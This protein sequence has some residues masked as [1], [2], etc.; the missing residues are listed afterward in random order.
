MNRLIFREINNRSI[1]YLYYP[2]GEEV[3]GKIEYLFS[4]K[5]AR[6]AKK[7]KNDEFGYF[8]YKATLKVEECAGKKNLPLQFTQEWVN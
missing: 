8:A 2:E 7:A 4:D 6:I 3:F 1:I 5:K